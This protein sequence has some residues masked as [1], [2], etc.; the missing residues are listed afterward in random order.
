MGNAIVLRGI[1]V[2]GECN[3]FARDRSF[4]GVCNSF[5]RDRNFLGVCNSFA[6]DLSF[7]GECNSFARDCSF[8]AYAIVLRGI[9]VFGRMQ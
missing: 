6:R 4:L 7:L 8:W 3:S 5:A 2:F 1:V 9:V